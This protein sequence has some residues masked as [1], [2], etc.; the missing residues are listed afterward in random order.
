MYDYH[1]WGVA[2][3][4]QTAYPSASQLETLCRQDLD[5]FAQTIEEMRT[6]SFEE[7]LKLK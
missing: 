5:K 4:Y 2:N 7:N 1:C 6:V 3:F